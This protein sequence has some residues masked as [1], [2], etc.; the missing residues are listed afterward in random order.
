MLISYT[1]ISLTQNFVT[2]PT[3]PH[4]PSAPSAHND[5]AQ[6]GN[7]IEVAS[8][9]WSTQRVPGCCLEVTSSVFCD[10]QYFLLRILS[11]D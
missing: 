4:V 8:G 6:H 7:A 10:D 11:E 9:P 3:S 2:P 5:S 1:S